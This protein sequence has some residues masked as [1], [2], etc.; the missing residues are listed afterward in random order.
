MLDVELVDTPGT[1]R[2]NIWKLKLIN[3]RL[4]VRPRI[5]DIYRGISDFKS[6]YQPRSSL[7]MDEKGICLLTPTVLW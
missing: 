1:N 4:K 3:L 7:A 5:L 2:R 6:N